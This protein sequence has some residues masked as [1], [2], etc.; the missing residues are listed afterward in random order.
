MVK[1]IWRMLF[2]ILSHVPVYH[3]GQKAKKNFK[4]I[5]IKV[6]RLKKYSNLQKPKEIKKEFKVHNQI[7]CYYINVF[8]LS[9]RNQTSYDFFVYLGIILFVGAIQ[10]N[11]ENLQKIFEMTMFHN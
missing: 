9:L 5:K 1:V 2:S 3:H 4:F 6:K 11:L 8:E 7:K 10:Q